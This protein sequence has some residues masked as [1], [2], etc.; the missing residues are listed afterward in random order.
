MQCSNHFE[1]WICQHLLADSGQLADWNGRLE[2]FKITIF[3]KELDQ[4]SK[5]RNFNMQLYGNCA[6]NPTANT[7]FY[8]RRP[9]KKNQFFQ[10]YKKNLFIYINIHMLS[11]GCLLDYYWMLIGPPGW[12]SKLDTWFS[13]SKVKSSSAG[14][15]FLAK[16]PARKTPRRRTIHIMYNIMNI[17]PRRLCVVC[18]SK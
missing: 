8:P 15:A 17:Y 14:R 5:I 18:N 6:P 16:V 12:R 1:K 11:F 7:K 3:K 4:S 13:S 2:S 10:K 9:K